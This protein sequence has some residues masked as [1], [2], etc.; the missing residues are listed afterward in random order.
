M[1]LRN[2]LRKKACVPSKPGLIKDIC[3]HKS[4][5]LFSTGV[6]VR[7]SRCLERSCRTACEVVELGFLMA[8]DSSRIT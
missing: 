3:D 5:V 7:M 1:G 8:C 6:P 4:I 2:S